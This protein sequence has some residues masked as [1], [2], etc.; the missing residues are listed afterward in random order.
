[1]RPAG[2]PDRAALLSR[3]SEETIGHDRSE[4]HHDR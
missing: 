2:K 1:V 4:E 3:L